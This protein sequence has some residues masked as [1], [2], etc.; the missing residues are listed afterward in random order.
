MT[1]FEF[2]PQFDPT[3]GKPA[4]PKSALSKYV[5]DYC[6]KVLDPNEF[7][8]GNPDP[9]Y[10]VHESGDTD[11]QFH[12]MRI[13]GHDVDVDRLF[14]DHREFRYCQDW[15]GRTFCELSLATEWTKDVNKQESIFHHVG[16]LACAMYVARL[17]VVK[18]MLDGG[19][20]YK[21][22]GLIA[23]N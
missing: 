19:Y 2:L 5:C 4:E 20:T 12:R 13:D 15:S 11:T 6:G 21:R 10:V 7:D 1:L 18:R 23:C 9:T 17:R 3:T 14:D 22:M 8:V 16:L